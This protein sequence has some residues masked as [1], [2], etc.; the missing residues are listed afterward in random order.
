M[1]RYDSQ[2]NLRLPAG[3]KDRL[4][5]QAEM[6]RRSLTAEITH[7]LEESL[8][9]QACAGDLARQIAAALAPLLTESRPSQDEPDRRPTPRELHPGAPE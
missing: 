5:A 4:L 1:A 2:V 6:N 9:A 3:M 8:S 7:R